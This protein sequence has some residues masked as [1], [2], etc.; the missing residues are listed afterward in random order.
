MM[1]T[2][3]TWYRYPCD[4]DGPDVALIKRLAA[5]T[6]RALGSAS[7][8]AAAYGKLC[9]AMRTL[10]TDRLTY[11]SNVIMIDSGWCGATGAGGYWAAASEACNRS[12]TEA[13]ALR[14][15][16]IDE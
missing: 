12:A 2:W 5:R 13:L 16:E 6:G 8:Y 15:K 11:W 10:P 14:S 4:A 9:E 1:G 3:N 7:K